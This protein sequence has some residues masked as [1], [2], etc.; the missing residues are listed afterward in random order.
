MIAHTEIDEW[1]TEE[2][3]SSSIINYLIESGFKVHKEES[4]S[5]ERK[6]KV[7]VAS[8]F[9]TKEIIHVKSLPEE[10]DRA[11]LLH[12]TAANIYPSGSITSLTD[13]ILN[14][15]ANFGK[16]YSDRSADVAMALPKADR[17]IAITE[18][19]QDYFISN[20]LSMKVYFVNKDGEVEIIN[21]NVKQ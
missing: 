5:E 3:I 19:L 4:R 12:T 8:K 17:Y 16:Y 20:D 2:F 9:F 11:K 1:Y 13:T 15:L 18:R 14:S 7:I 6:E 21:L 10:S